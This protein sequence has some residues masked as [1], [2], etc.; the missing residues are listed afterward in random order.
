[1]QVATQTIDALLRLPQ[2]VEIEADKASKKAVLNLFNGMVVQLPGSGRGVSLMRK[3]SGRVKLG[4]DCLITAAAPRCTVTRPGRHDQGARRRRPDRDPAHLGGAGQ[5]AVRGD[6]MSAVAPVQAPQRRV[7]RWVWAGTRVP[8]VAVPRVLQADDPRPTRRE[9]RQ[10]EG[11]CAGQE[12]RRRWRAIAQH[13]PG[14][15][16]HRPATRATRSGQRRGRSGYRD[17]ADQRTALR[18]GSTP[19]SRPRSSVPGNVRYI[20]T[21]STGRTEGSC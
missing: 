20:C 4:S 14:A 2:C 8:R 5:A 9:P 12:A 10:G 6:G 1:M 13:R 21:N 16:R 17:P 19:P 7:R 15:G 11:C 18:G 3:A